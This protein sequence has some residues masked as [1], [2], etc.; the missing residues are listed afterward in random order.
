MTNKERC[1]LRYVRNR[2]AALEYA[3]KYREAHREELRDWQL[4][5]RKKVNRSPELFAQYFEY[6]C[7][8]RA[9]HADRRRE[10][11]KRYKAAHKR[12]IRMARRWYADRIRCQ[13]RNDPEFYALLRARGRAY[14]RKYKDIAGRIKAYKP[15]MSRRIPDTCCYDRVIDTRSVFIWNNLP[16]ASLVAGRAYRA[17]QWR[18]AHCDRFGEVCR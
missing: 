17:M 14:K 6:R 2:E 16:A 18:E 12:K 7:K 3:R 1:H 10:Y 13:C 11:N 5:Y 4:A 8:N 9:E 15:M